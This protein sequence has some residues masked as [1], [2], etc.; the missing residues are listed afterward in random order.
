M[1]NSGTIGHDGPGGSR[2]TVERVDEFA[3]HEVARTSGAT[4]GLAQGGRNLSPALASECK[5][6]YKSIFMPASQPLLDR[7]FGFILNDISRLTR[8]QFDRR[9][10]ELKLTRAQWLFLYHLARQPGCSQSELAESLQIERISVSRQADRLEKAGWIERQDHQDDAR[11][12]HLFLTP[13]AERVVE[14]LARLAEQL[15]EDYLDGIS[16]PRRTALINDLLQVKTNLLRLE[17]EAK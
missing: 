17:A 7:S 1:A 6:T 9:V 16:A 4:P 11:A 8:R 14:R 15:R 5:P 13:K 10:S 2:A 3:G 12:Y